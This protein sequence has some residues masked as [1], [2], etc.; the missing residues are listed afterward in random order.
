M[1][2]RLRSV[3]LSAPAPLAEADTAHAVEI[4]PRVWW[5]GHLLEGDH[6]QCHAYLLEQGDQSVLFDL[7]AAKSF[8][9]V[10]AKVEEVVALRDIRWFVVHHQDPDITG[11]LPLLDQLVARPDAVVVTHWRAEALLRHYGL[12]LPFW[13]IEDHGW[14]LPLEDRT[15]QFVL[16]PYL[17]FPGAFVSFDPESGVLF[18]SDLFGGFT[19]EPKLVAEDEGYFEAIRLFHEHYMPSQEILAHGLS[20]IEPLPIQMIAP[21]HGSIIPG[22]MVRPIIARLKNLECGLYL[23]VRNE[24]DIRR[25]SEMNRVLRSALK[26]LT[27]TREF[28]ELMQQLTT[29]MQDAL[30]IEALELYASTS[31]GTLRFDAATR[32]RGVPE[33]PPPHLLPWLGMSRSAWQVERS[34]TTGPRG[35]PMVVLPLFGVDEGHAQH[36]AVLR[37]AAPVLGTELGGHMLEELSTPLEVAVDREVLLRE[38]RQRREELYELATRDALTGLYNR[39]YLRGAAA[40]MA[41]LQD[42]GQVG[43]VVMSMLDID[44]FKAVNDTFGHAAGDEVL[45]RIGAALQETIR[46]GDLAVRMGGEEIAVLHLRPLASTDDPASLAE[47]L[48]RVVSGLEF[49]S[50]AAGLRVTVSAGVAVRQARGVAGR[51]HRPGG[52]GAVRG[53][54]GRPGSGVAGLRGLRLSRAQNRTARPSAVG[55]TGPGVSRVR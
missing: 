32:F 54:G 42:R 40:R 3:P 23:M 29:I 1:V 45:A 27:V 37:L 17:H 25:L 53:E 50:P 18:S 11:A 19:S 12:D 20:R 46:D 4:A 28:P 41:A 2:Q 47:R 38:V 22:P 55:V 13:R 7:G 16:T 43:Q 30:P 24:T 21:Q 51:P 9:H 48:R 10:L 6:F 31:Q 15:L 35:Q 44:H 5:V 49:A 33:D 26:S 36:L 39:H 34:F 52:P 8:R 14:V